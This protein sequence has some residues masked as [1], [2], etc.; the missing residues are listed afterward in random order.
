ML[1]AK[2]GNSEKAWLRWALR[3]LLV[4][5]I[6]LATALITTAIDRLADE[7]VALRYEVQGIRIEGLEGR[8]LL[9]SRIVRLEARLE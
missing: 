9:T 5:S 3:V 2:E 6:A 8:A 4:G 7:M 1:V